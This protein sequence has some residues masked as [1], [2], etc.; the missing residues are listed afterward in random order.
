[1]NKLKAQI[2]IEGRKENLGYFNDEK[3]A[4]RA[5]NEKAKELFKEFAKLNI[6]END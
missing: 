2:Q 5:Y 4:A 3:E 1:M 6:I